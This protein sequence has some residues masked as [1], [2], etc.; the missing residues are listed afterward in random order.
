L[1]ENRAFFIPR[2]S[3][4]APVM[5]PRRN[6]DNVRYERTRMAWLLDGEKRYVEPFRQ[7]RVT[8]REIDGQTSCDIAQ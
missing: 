4:D 5:G 8:D 1:V 2:H 7:W 3:T 6:I